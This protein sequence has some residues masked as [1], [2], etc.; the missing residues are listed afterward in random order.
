M[1]SFVMSGPDPGEVR[2]AVNALWPAQHGPDKVKQAIAEI[3]ITKGWH[4]KPPLS[5]KL[6]MIGM[7]PRGSWR[8]A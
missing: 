6:N 8:A 3:L 4:F 5:F 2:A 1:K 7:S